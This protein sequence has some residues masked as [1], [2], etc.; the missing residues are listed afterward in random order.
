MHY[1]TKD[2][3]LQFWDVPSVMYYCRVH[4]EMSWDRLLCAVLVYLHFLEYDCCCHIPMQTKLIFEGEML[5]ILI[6]LLQLSAAQ[7]H[8]GT[9]LYCSRT[10]SPP[11]F[12]LMMQCS[13][14]AVS[15]QSDCKGEGSSLSARPAR[16]G[17]PTLIHNTLAFHLFPREVAKTRVL[18]PWWRVCQDTPR[19]SS[20][21]VPLRI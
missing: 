15:A 7:K 18:F 20:L 4:L 8:P 19:F 21:A 3:L 10:I 14:R 1:E 13:A 17:W 16:P 9:D 11:L 2:F 12:N 5:N 6:P